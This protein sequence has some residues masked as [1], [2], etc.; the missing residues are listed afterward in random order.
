MSSRPL[1]VRVEQQISR[2][3]ERPPPLLPGWTFRLVV[4][5][6][7]VSLTVDQALCSGSRA[8]LEHPA[9]RLFRAGTD[10]FRDQDFR[11]EGIQSIPELLE[12]VPLH[13]AAVCAGTVLR[14]TGN[15]GTLG[16]FAPE[17]VEHP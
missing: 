7:E 9:D 13:E 14:G 10:R 2:L 5:A 1:R 12:R 15:K 8:L 3:S 4:E 16:Q 6:R 11:L 17:P